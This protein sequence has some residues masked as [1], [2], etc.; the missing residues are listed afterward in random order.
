MITDTSSF[1]RDG[2]VALRVAFARDTIPVLADIPVAPDAAEVSTQVLQ[3]RRS[4]ADSLVVWTRSTVVA[5]AIRAAR[6]SGWNAAIY[7]GPTG[8]DPV[9]RQQLD[10]HPAWLDGTTF[11]SFRITAEV[12]PAPFNVFRAAYEKRFG[13]EQ[14][15]VQAGGRAVL[16]PPDWAMYS[17]DTVNLLSACL[18]ASKGQLGTPLMSALD[19]IVVTGANGDERGF[20]PTSREG[21][22]F[23]DMYFGRFRDKRF[24][25]VTD[26]ILSTN[27]PAIPQ[28]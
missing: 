14:V 17:F 10:D 2:A 5:A 26:D 24:A 27:L 28:G 25:P 1:G 13:A 11:V 12:G 20:T 23:D 16:A 22:S 15:G 18:T 6:S 3:A 21:V 7:T 9:V 8:E 4:G 19:T